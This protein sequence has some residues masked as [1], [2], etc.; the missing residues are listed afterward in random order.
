MVDADHDFY[1]P[2]VTP[3]HQP[4]DTKTRLLREFEEKWE[5]KGDD[6]YGLVKHNNTILQHQLD[7]LS[8][9]LDTVA[10]EAREEAFK[11][12]TNIVG[13]DVLVRGIYGGLTIISR[14]DAVEALRLQS[15]ETKVLPTK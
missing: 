2:I 13:S 15:E 11:E 1:Y 10:R 8:T 4:E 6:R 3:I 9:A 12:A 7:W 14:K 5:D